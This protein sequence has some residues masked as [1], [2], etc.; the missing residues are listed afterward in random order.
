VSCLERCLRTLHRGLWLGLFLFCTYSGRAGAQ[1]DTEVLAARALFDEG[2]R[3]MAAG[4]YQSACAKFEESQRLRAGIGTRF[5]LAECY[6]KLGKTASA[7]SLYLAVAAETRAQ[8]QLEREQLAREAAARLEPRLSRLTIVVAE[9]GAG[10]VLRLNGTELGA[11]SFGVATPM[12]PGRYEVEARAPGREPWQGEV[13]VP[14]AGDTTLEVPALAPKLA[15]H[16][17]QK[18]GKS[19]ALAAAANEQNSPA[20]R[21]RNRTRTAAYVAGAVGLSGLSLGTLFGLRALGKN[22]EAKKICV[23]RETQCLDEEISKH[24]GLKKEATEAR[25]AAYLG[26]GVGAA[27]M[28]AGGALLLLTKAPAHEQQA[29]SLTPRIDWTSFGLRLSGAF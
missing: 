10:L 7:W 15:A 4:D 5:N 17:K 18:A 12:D 23:E 2:R 13:D 8:N 9:A 25:T 20:D 22:N 27:G 6:E 24:E 3:L 1:Q 21:P 19:P 26:F 14:D 28:L 16:S 11:A 29:L